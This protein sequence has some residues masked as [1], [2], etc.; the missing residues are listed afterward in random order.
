MKPALGKT[1][2]IYL[3]FH[4]VFTRKE[5]DSLPTCTAQAMQQILDP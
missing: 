3:K 4:P 2:K 1:M 5:Q